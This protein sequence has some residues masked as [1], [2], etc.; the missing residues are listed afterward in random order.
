MI[1]LLKHLWL[2]YQIKSYANKIPFYAIRE[3]GAKKYY[4]Q[5]E[6]D[7]ILQKW[8]FNDKYAQIAYAILLSKKAFAEIVSNEYEYNIIRQLIAKY[9]F[10]GDAEFTVCD[11]LSKSY[12][13][14]GAFYKSTPLPIEWRADASFFDCLDLCKATNLFKIVKY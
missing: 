9:Y 12:F 6:V 11:L 14:V 5:Y 4:S 10:N 1:E 7:S 13:R 8:S 2:I 3:F